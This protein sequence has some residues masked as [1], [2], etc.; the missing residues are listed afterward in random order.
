MNDRRPHSHWPWGRS[1]TPRWPLSKRF[2]WI[3]RSD[4]RHGGSGARTRLRA[5][6][7]PRPRMCKDWVY[8]RSLANWRCEREPQAVASEPS[9]CRRS[10]LRTPSA[11]DKRGPRPTM[12]GPDCH[13][14]AIVPAKSGARSR[15]DARP[16]P[17]PAPRSREPTRTV[18]GAAYAAPIGLVRGRRQRTNRDTSRCDDPDEGRAYGS[19]APTSAPAKQGRRYRE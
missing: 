11:T 6:S 8:L 15:R 5:A 3:G 19:G 16:G 17:R 1:P 18:G 9:A 4:H 13:D 7:P 14:L 2:P 10:Q 12:R